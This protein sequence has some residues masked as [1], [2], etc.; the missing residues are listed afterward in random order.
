MLIGAHVS[1]SGGVEKAV[2]RA[3]EIGAEC[4]QIFASSPRAWAFK[5][6]SDA[7][8]KAFRDGVVKAKL[9]P[10]VLHGIYLVGIG[11][12]DPEIVRK[13]TESLTLH[14]R[15]AEQLGALGLVFHP[16][17]H[18]GAGLD[19]MFDQF[20]K[21]A[22]Q[23]LKD[24]PGEAMLLLET[25]A[26]QGDHIGSKFSEL[27][28]LIKAIKSPRLGVCF[29]TQHTYAAGYNVVDKK[30]LDDALAEFDREI[31]LK[32]LRC[33]HANDSKKELGSAVDRHD[34]IGD[35]LIG[36]AGFKTIFSHKAFKDVPFYLEV[37][38]FEGGGPDKKNVN[39][40]KALRKEAGVKP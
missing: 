19:A 17:S 39:I 25:S 31:G 30:G 28:R 15:T 35:G 20:V 38:G 40:L 16:A 6:V 4:I 24:A 34:N 18:R 3:V 14:L 22:R 37:P 13:S 33:A 8:A 26:G 36:R 32:L 29:D 5:P 21:G 9:G 11:T 12:P 2:G 7:S 23:V 27:G 10:T 1:S